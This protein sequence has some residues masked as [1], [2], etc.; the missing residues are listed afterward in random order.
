MLERAHPK[1]ERVFF[2]PELGPFRGRESFACIKRALSVPGRTHLRP[3]RVIS[4]LR[5]PLLCLKGPSPI[6]R[7]PFSC[8]RAHLRPER[9]LSLFMPY[10]PSP[11]LREPSSRLIGH[12]PDN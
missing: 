6:L 9:A 4:Y 10:G 5:G 11:S 7:E 3:E 8:Q 2:T 12:I 1:P